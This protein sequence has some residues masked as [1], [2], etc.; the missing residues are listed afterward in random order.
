[1]I[2]GR[3]EVALEEKIFALLPRFKLKVTNFSA[4][5]P[6]ILMA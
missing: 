3:K 1:M 6:D 2:F 5:L 4:L